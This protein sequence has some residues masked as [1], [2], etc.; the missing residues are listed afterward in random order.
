M[1]NVMQVTGV[2]SNSQRSLFN[3]QQ[4]IPTMEASDIFTVDFT[5]SSTDLY[6]GN[7]KTPS[8]QETNSA[9]YKYLF[10]HSVTK[11]HSVESMNQ[12][13]TPSV[14]SMMEPK[15]VILLLL[16]GN[17]YRFYSSSSIE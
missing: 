11:K 2:E 9:V 17:Q 4:T 8:I 13:S 3:V 7:M 12:V 10:P 1:A 14:S 16:L 15:R 6:N 5:S